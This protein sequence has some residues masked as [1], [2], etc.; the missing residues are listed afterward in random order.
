MEKPTEKLQAQVEAFTGSESFPKGR[1]FSRDQIL[2]LAYADKLATGEK[3]GPEFERLAKLYK[4]QYVDFLRKKE[5]RELVEQLEGSIARYKD[6][7]SA[8]ADQLKDQVTKA[9]E[10]EKAPSFLGSGGTATTFKAE[11]DGVPYAFKLFGLYDEDEKSGVERAYDVYSD[12]RTLLYAKGIRRVPQLVAHSLKDQVVVMSLKPGRPV[13][14]NTPEE[15]QQFTDDEI[16]QLIHTVKALQE[17]GLAVDWY[18]ENLLH[19]DEEGFSVL[20]PFYVGDNPRYSVEKQVMRLRRMLVGKAYRDFHY[21][22]LID[23]CD[24]ST[25]QNKK[26][27]RESLEL[28]LRIL[29]ITKEHFPDI[30]EAYRRSEPSRLLELGEVSEPCE[31]NKDMPY[32]KFVLNQA[33]TILE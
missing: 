21:R 29:R 1:D 17:R 27:R 25:A 9:G 22:D 13:A 23:Y 26:R 12:V 18:P 16:T 32:D 14:E 5:N 20:D 11:A 24:K 4:G 3:Q 15:S 2:L 10:P 31:F 7:F 30:F 6:E 19:D 8:I 28:G 33:Q